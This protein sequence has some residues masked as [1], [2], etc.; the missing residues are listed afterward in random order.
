MWVEVYFIETWEDSDMPCL[1][2]ASQDPAIKQ[3]AEQIANDPSFKQVTEQLQGQFGSMFG[4]AARA[5]A[6]EAAA[7]ADPAAAAAAFD[8]SKYMQAMT[9]MFQNQDFMKMAEQLGK[10]IIEASRFQNDLIIV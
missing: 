4:D 6:A 3:M 7:P 2:I 8:P 1:F 9:G 5:G 10:S